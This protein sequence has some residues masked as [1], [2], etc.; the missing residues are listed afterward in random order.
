LN[1]KV[2]TTIA[3]CSATLTLMTTAAPALAATTLTQTQ[4]AQSADQDLKS[5]IDVN[6]AN[7]PQLKDFGKKPWSMKDT[8]AGS[9]VAYFDGSSAYKVPFANEERAKVTKGITIETTFNYTGDVKGDHA[10]FSNKEQG[11]L[12]LSV[13]D[14][15]LVFSADDGTGFKEAK[16]T[17]K[18][19]K[20]I[21]AVGVVDT[22]NKTTNL[23]VNGVLVDSQANSGNLKLST[24]NGAYQFV[25]GG[26]SA[27]NNK[28]ESAMTGKVKLA[29]VYGQ[30][31]SAVQA[32]KLSAD[33]HSDMKPTIQSFSTQLVGASEVIEGHTYDL[34]VHTRQL[35]DGD[36]D[37][38]EY[39]VAFDAKKFDY[40]GFDQT[41]S[42]D[43]TQ[44]KKVNDHTL[45]V[46]STATLSSAPTS[47]YKATRLVR[48]KLKA[49]AIDKKDTTANVAIKN[50]SASVANESVKG[51]KFDTKQ[52]QAVTIKAKNA[53]DLN[54]DGIVGAGDISLA[55]ANKKVEIAK[56]AEIRPYKHVIVLTTDGGGNPWDP[57]GMYYAKDDQTKPTW[58]TDPTILAKR[59]NKYTMD[60]FNKKFAMSTDAKS[61]QPAISAQNYSSM[62]HGL[63]W[64][65]MDKSY[66]M[67]NSTAADNYFGDF[68]KK[69]PKYPSVFKV[70]KQAN[71]YQGAAAF[72]EWKQILNGI[73]EPDAGVDTNPSASLKSFDDVADYVG[74]DKF[75]DTSLVYMQSDYMDGQGHGKGWYDDNYWDKYEQYD[76]LFKKVMDKL[77]VTGHSHDTLV[78]ANS[79]HG[80]SMHNHGSNLYTNDP[81]N[82][83]IFI[84][85][86][87]E[88]I[89][90]GHR[91][92]GGSNADISALILNA[93]QVKQPSSMTGKVFDSSAFLDQTELVKK[94]RQVESINLKNSQNKFDLQFKANGNRQV[95]T[96]D[97]RI[98]LAGQTLDKVTVPAGAKVLRQDVENGILKLT[99]SFD[100]QPT[101]DM[102][103]VTLKAGKTKAATKVTIKQAMIGTDKGAEVLPDITTDAT[104][105]QPE[106][107]KPAP[108]PKPEPNKP[109]PAPK[110]EPGKPAPSTPGNGGAVTTPSTPGN[111]SSSTTTK[112]TKP[113]KPNTDT[114]ATASES[115]KEK[116]AKKN[117][118][119]G[120]IVYAQKKVGFY[121]KAKFTKKNRY[122]FFAAKP[123]NKWAQFKIVTKKGN[124]YQVKDI[125][126]G[127]KTY[128]KTGYIT[129]S[130]KYVTSADYTKKPIKVKVINAKGLSAYNS[131]TLKGKHTTYKRGTMLKIKKLVKSKGKLRLQLKN[132][133][134][135]TVDKHMIHAYFAHK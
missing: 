33:A 132:G 1:S 117:K 104:A 126:K 85:I 98:D 29:R 64:A 4:T 30:A 17:L 130:S 99:L 97:T 91:L 135:I 22:V 127:S 120:K 71:P 80:G 40:L 133:K 79:D 9:K 43:A 131:K 116:P 58:S 15:N 39:D 24:G 11:G 46:T 88:T 125:N 61:V 90:S 16:T 106:P 128:G 124:R 56:N 57:A 62:L 92:K 82:N 59:K 94:N 81:S 12:G 26:D 111:N 96:L 54:G 108:A 27:A 23:Y 123:Q 32:K 102:A 122:K 20:W 50:V 76:G 118:L 89:N 53:N 66:Q 75:N 7:V 52:E 10:I 36:V 86:G 6:F 55:S 69:N 134:Y 113:A 35:S 129:S 13:K 25:I 8:K 3:L 2:L 93:L 37:K 51:A 44:V 77:E 100:K 121:K 5:I 21:H 60:L 49:K 105:K 101:A 31:A 41:L 18:P 103:T 70:L 115:H 38:V 114:N 19:G 47:N 110:P 63:P 67:N 95:R 83:N 34:N 112:P 107:N 65:N 14:G 119:K 48:I 45:H 74:S 42:G 28:L 84:G 73:T 72:A 87:G 68:G 78:I 109:A